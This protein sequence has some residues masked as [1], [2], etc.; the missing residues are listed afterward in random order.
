M[1][2]LPEHKLANIILVEDN[3]FDIEYIKSIFKKNNMVFN[4]NIF[5][6]GQEILDFLNTI[7]L[8]SKIDYPDIIL[9]DLNLPKITGI[10]I[11]KFIQNNKVLKKI[12]VFI[13]SDSHFKE[14]ILDSY[15]NGA[16]FYMHKPFKINQFLESIKKINTIKIHTK[17]GVLSICRWP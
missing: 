8:S 5:R 12:P 16:K 7:P 14:D 9:L 17:G 6:D 3:L 10:E 15:K 1:D 13:L 2:N 11:L 4:W